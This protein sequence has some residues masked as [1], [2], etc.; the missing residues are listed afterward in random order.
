MQVVELGAGDDTVVFFATHLNYR[1]EEGER[2]DS[3]KKIRSLLAGYAD[4][5]VILAG[6]LNASP[7]ARRCGSSP[8]TGR[9]Q[10]RAAVDVPR[11]GAG[12]ADRLRARA[13]GSRG[14]RS[15]RKCACWTRPWRRTIGRCWR[16]CERVPQ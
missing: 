16:C 15:S 7:T 1:P 11:R 2:L 8:S 6:D 5:P 14:G 9:G 10:R 3:V 12:E 13:S 4:T